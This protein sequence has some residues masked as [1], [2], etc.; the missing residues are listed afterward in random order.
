[1][2]KTMIDKFE[3][4]MITSRELVSHDLTEN[5]MAKTI[6]KYNSKTNNKICTLDIK[7]KHNPHI[8]LMQ[9]DVYKH[10]TPDT[11]N[12]QPNQTGK[13]PKVF[14]QSQLLRNK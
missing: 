8:C 5:T 7:D 9:H 11:K 1:M 13:R 14:F 6:V 10:E 12:I 4:S 2:I 3:T